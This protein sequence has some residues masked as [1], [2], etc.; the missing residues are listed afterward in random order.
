MST[1][2]IESGAAASLDHQKQW[3]EFW[4]AVAE[5]AS[6]AIS[7]VG[8]DHPRVDLL[9]NAVRACREAAGLPPEPVA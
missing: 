7:L 4:L 2:G 5:A 6:I 9:R 1:N 8:A 3:D